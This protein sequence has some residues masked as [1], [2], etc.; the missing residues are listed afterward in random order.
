M[1][2]KEG[3]TLVELL[4]VIVV[5][6]VIITF[7]TPAVLNILVSAEN[8]TYEENR[9]N[10]LDGA[11]TYGLR[12]FNLT[13]CAEGF[14]PTDVNSTSTPGCLRKVTIK[15]LKDKGY[16]EDNKGNCNEDAIIIV[17]NEYKNNN[18]GLD[19]GEYKTFAPIGICGESE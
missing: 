8:N 12:E 6:G 15:E 16:I 17:Y 2:K 3:F 4:A 11:L 10:A 1:D 18:S 9:R 5:L 14:V 13:V 19:V 7:A